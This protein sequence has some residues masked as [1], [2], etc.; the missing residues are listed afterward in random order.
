MLE[1]LRDNARWLAAG[2]L[3]ALISSFGQTYFIS[4]FAGAIRAEFGLSHGGW[5]A[6]YS[7]AT[8]VSAMV[9]L[10]AGGLTDRYRVRVLA[11][12]V[13]P[14]FALACL[15][16][17]LVPSV[18]LLAP[19]LFALRLAGQGM[20]VHVAVVAMGRW[21]VANRG[22]A[23]AVAVLGISLGEALM[24]L[25][26]VALMGLTGWRALWAVAAVCI[27]LVLP[28][29]LGLLRRER[30]PQDDIAANPAPGMG[31][32]HWRRGDVLHHW[33][34]WA[35][36]PLILGPPAFITALFFQQVH[37]AGIKDIAHLSLV[38][39]FP[40]YSLAG[41]GSMVLSG[42]ALDRLGTAPLIPF[43]LLPIAAGFAL[44]AAAGNV[45]ALALGLMLVGV[46]SGAN[47]T[48]PNAF[49]AEFYG[50]AHLGA[51]KALATALMVMGSALGPILT[52]VLIDAGVAFEL[53][54]GAIAVY[55]LAAAAL[56]AAAIRRAAPMLPLRT[57]ALA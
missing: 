27:L 39:L 28:L 43:L 35:M 48:L 33:L 19:V 41:V 52:G 32:R 21:F 37:L 13:L 16:M 4:V 5:G 56:A 31:G 10:W 57:M 26:F 3:L 11:M 47:S 42:I 53:Q 12:V 14:A 45:P 22:K 46:T 38:A 15:A 51:I 20:T 36:A 25:G 49:W 2:F 50:T 44:I 34:F 8:F 7:A 18:W 23:L 17:A 40:L 29:L 30:T 6:I 24:P 1:F 54:L 55:F 9:M